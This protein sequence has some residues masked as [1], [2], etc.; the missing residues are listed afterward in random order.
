MRNQE[1]TVKILETERMFSINF[2][3]KLD[4]SL[5]RKIIGYLS[6]T[7]RKKVLLVDSIQLHTEIKNNKL[8]G[9]IETKK[10]KGSR[11]IVNPKFEGYYKSLENKIV[12]RYVYDILTLEELLKEMEGMRNSNNRYNHRYEFLEEEDKEKELIST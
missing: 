9:Y 1:I 12:T 8:I 7:Y 3:E 5:V 11:R 4:N 2:S 6:K 10:G